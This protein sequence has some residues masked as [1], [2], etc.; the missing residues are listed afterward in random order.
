MSDFRQ[1]PFGQDVAFVVENVPMLR[2]HVEARLARMYNISALSDDRG[3]DR[4]KRPRTATNCSMFP[5]AIVC[6]LLRNDLRALTDSRNNYVALEKTDGIRYLLLLTTLE[7]IPYAV[8][9]DRKMELRVVNLD[10]SLALFE[11]EAL[12]DGELAQSVENGLYTF[13]IFDLIYTNV[14]TQNGDRIYR[15]SSY[16]QRMRHANHLVKTMWQKQVSTDAQ[17]QVYSERPVQ[18]IKNTFY[19]KV[20][21][22][23]P[24]V[25]FNETF[26]RVIEQNDWTHHGYKID[27][28]IFVKSRQTVEPFRNENQFKYKPTHLHTIDVQLYRERIGSPYELLIKNSRNSPQFYSKL[29]LCQENTSFVVTHE[30]EIIRHEQQKRNYIVECSWNSDQQCWIL[31]MPRLDKQTPNALNTIEL[32]RKN[33]QENITLSELAEKF[34]SLERREPS[35][36]TFSNTPVVTEQKTMQQTDETKRGCFVHPSRLQNISQSSSLLPTHQP[37][38]YDPVDNVHVKKNRDVKPVSEHSLSPIYQESI[39]SDCTCEHCQPKTSVE[40][41]NFC[42]ADLDQLLLQAK[43]LSQLQKF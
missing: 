22:Y 9:I 10:F 2:K 14:R 39:K 29:V 6:S 28:F 5:G 16:T 12:F 37:Q 13:L 34:N 40:K 25:E 21:R 36:S 3:D 17:Y 26:K 19:I 30:Q 33:I 18:A 38:E 43:T 23:V 27:G 24:L 42:L 8:L 32:T 41:P 31:K 35:S 11:Q 20:K 4:S 15:D 1:E 7:N